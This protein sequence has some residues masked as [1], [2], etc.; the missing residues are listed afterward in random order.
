M[1]T[2]MQVSCPDLR[3]HRTCK[4]RSELCSR[5]ATSSPRFGSRHRKS[6]LR[7]GSN[8]SDPQST[9]CRDR[10]ASAWEIQRGQEEAEREIRS[11]SKPE[12]FCARGGEHRQVSNISISTKLHR[13]FVFPGDLI[14]AQQ[15]TAF[16]VP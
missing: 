11:S 16:K 4:G 3:Q 15:I 13:L 12:G 14:V 10:D 5:D 1:A 6:A 7:G 9:T 8:Q 2:K